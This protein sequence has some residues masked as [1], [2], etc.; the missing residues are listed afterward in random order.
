L[1]EQGVS[2]AFSLDVSLR[3]EVASYGLRGKDGIFRVRRP[4]RRHERGLIM[5]AQI[6]FATPFPDLF[7]MG[8]GGTHFATSQSE[9]REAVL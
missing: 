6:P 9:K 5:A 7:G 8:S 3:P 2:T 4:V 1:N